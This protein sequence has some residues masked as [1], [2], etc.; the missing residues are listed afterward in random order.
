[1]VNIFYYMN[2]RRLNESLKKAVEKFLPTQG[3]FPCEI[4]GLNFHRIDN[5]R[6]ENCFYTPKIIVMLQG[7]KCVYVGKD[8]YEY[9]AGQCIVT[10]VDVPATSYVVEA[11]PQKPAMAVS[12]DLDMEILSRMLEDIPEVGSKNVDSCQTMAVSISDSHMLD[13]FLRLVRL[14][15]SKEETSVIAPIIVREIYSRLLISALGYHIREFCTRGTRN[16][17]V[18]RA[19]N[20]LKRN[21]SKPFKIE[22]LAKY[23]HMA[24]TTFHRHFRKVTSVSPIQY[25]K[26]L[27]LHEARHLMISKN[28]T[29]SEAAYS[30]GYESPTQ[31]S[32]EYKRLFGTSPKRDALSAV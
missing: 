29:V 27:R 10:G 15:D 32:R 4:K 11:N 20:W 21:Y 9:A 1:M 16:N 7:K 8:K 12:L 5:S 24:P 6:S 28:E 31:F 13:A 25:Q 23:V 17:G 19:V 14:L 3:S 2:V 26:N 22:E 18:M 30:V